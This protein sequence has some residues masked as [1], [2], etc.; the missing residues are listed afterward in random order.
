M[1]HL[2]NTLTTYESP[3][4][5]YQCGCGRQFVDIEMY[6]CFKCNKS[7]CKF[8]VCQDEIETFFCRFCLDTQ[9]QSEAQQ[10]KNQCCR[11]LECPICFTV[12]QIAVNQQKNERIYYY[13][14]NFCKWDT[15]TIDFKS[16]IINGLLQKFTFYK[17]RYLKSPQQELYTKLLALYKWQME[18]LQTLEK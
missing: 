9:S 17:G 18:E 4:V 13:T 16:N 7:L 10:G 5:H 2:G 8:C 1:K 12:L 3:F 15:F 14:C 6:L 11:Y